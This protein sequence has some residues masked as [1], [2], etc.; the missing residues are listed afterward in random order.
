MRACRK[1][2]AN[3][4]PAI[5]SAGKNLG[6]RVA[7]GGIIAG[8]SAV[9]RRIQSESRCIG[10]DRFDIVLRN[11]A[12]PMGVKHQLGELRPRGQSIGTEQRG[13]DIPRLGADCQAGGSRF[14]FDEPGDILLPVRIAFD[15]ECGSLS[16]EELAKR[17][18]FLQTAGFDDERAMERRIGEQRFD[19][20]GEILKSGLDPDRTM[21]AEQPDRIGFVDE[22]ERVRRQ[23]VAIDTDE[24]ER[25][26]RI[27]HGAARR[28]CASA[29]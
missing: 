8:E 15:G 22:A 2:A 13:Q 26:V 29:R 24:L 1:A 14:G 23:L 27:G 25:I 7:H 16:F 28:S 4:A 18:V 12:G 21:T 3:K 9:D 10:D 11:L 20:G 19:R 5:S 6:S 17:R